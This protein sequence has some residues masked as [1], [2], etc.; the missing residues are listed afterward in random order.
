MFNRS[1]FC[2]QLLIQS[3]LMTQIVGKRTFLFDN[4]FNADIIQDSCRGTGNWNR[5]SK[6][7]PI[8]MQFMGV[9]TSIE[10]WGLLPLLILTRPWAYLMI[11]E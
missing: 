7:I 6:P 11:H 2:T 9:S 4:K 1:G 5:H 8:E 3:D 10:V